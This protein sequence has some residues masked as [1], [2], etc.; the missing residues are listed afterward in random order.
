M[1]KISNISCVMIVKNAE[2]SIRDV[3]NA[4]VNFEDVVLYS[5]NSTDATDSIAST[6]D[7][8]T[9]IQ[10]EFIGF[11]PTKNRATTYAKNDWILSLDADEVL[12]KE[13]INNIADLKLDEKKLYS[14]LRIN[15]YKKTQIK[16]C[17]GN[18]III[19]LYN[20]TKTKFTNKKVHEKIIDDNF[21]VEQLSGVVKHYPYAT[22]TDF[23]I[24]LDRY[25]TI[26]AKDNVGKKTSSPT[27][28][29]FNGAYSFIKT[30]FFKQGFRD[31]YVGLVIA[32]SHMVTNFYKY[33]KLY[34]LNKE[35]KK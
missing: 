26:Y 25:S 11:G 19:R 33:I 6:Y 2:S 10:G 18:D 17:W 5:N 12:S 7:N 28:A 34:E 14:I 1:T 16:H 8:V 27:K 20:R 13:F 15:Y 21:T 30:Y 31:G 29:F 24:K 35:L 9:L 3:L 4:L 23:I 22:I 32:Y